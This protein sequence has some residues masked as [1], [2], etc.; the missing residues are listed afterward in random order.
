MSIKVII[1][2][3]AEIQ[4]DTW[5]EFNEATCRSWLD[6]EGDDDWEFS[7]EGYYNYAA[8]RGIEQCEGDCIIFITHCTELQGE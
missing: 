5:E 8:I 3:G 7:E 2:D 6:I 1:I 4:E